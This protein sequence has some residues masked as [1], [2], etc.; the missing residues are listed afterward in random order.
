MPIRDKLLQAVARY[1]LLDPH[2]RVLVAV[3]GGQDSLTLLLVLHELAPELMIE[4]VVGHLHHSLRG[5]AAD[6]D[7]QC[8]GELAARLG[9]PY[10]TNRTDVA[11]LAAEEGIGVEEAG[12]RARYRFLER[13]ADEHGCGKIA[14][15][16]TATD[17][18]ETLLMNLF[19]GAGLHGLRA[20]P[21]RR[22]RIIR[23]LIL[24]SR[25]ETGAYCRTTNMTVCVDSTN[26]DPAPTRNRVRA[27]LLPQLEAEYGPGVEAALCRAAEHVWDEIAWTEPLVEE[28]LAAARE[29]EGL[30]A[31]RLADMPSGLRQRVLR[32]FLQ[33]AGHPLRDL[34]QERWE[35]LGALLKRGQTGRRL[36]LSH[37]LGV[38][39]VY[40]VLTVAQ[41]GGPD[42]DETVH[43]LPVPGRVELPG[44][45]ALTATVGTPP[46]TLPT[47]DASAAVLDAD[48]A[49][50][51]LLVRRARPGDCLVPLGMGGHKK[52]QDLFVDNK[53]PPAE[54]RPWVVTHSDGTILWV[55][56]HRLAATACVQRG[57]EQAVMLHLERP[58]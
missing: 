34:P 2:D 47:A 56:G 49:G 14:L 36:E 25:Q 31:P 41:P 45:Q 55:A 39:L 12:R 3:S 18:A 22:G 17:R 15:A 1:D 11:V 51:T 27:G 32:R 24:V 23:P 38:E 19:R 29:G 7:Q 33:E 21:P 26:L 20:I 52:L 28:A 35:A 6:A 8:V 57:T 5:E 4:L 46:E 30:S 42:T 48:R 40:G 16:H 58:G 10:V 9:L 13:A 50:A 53:V 43:E 37:G 44:G 54:R